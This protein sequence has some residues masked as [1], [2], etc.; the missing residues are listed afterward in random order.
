MKGNRER[1]PTFKYD[2]ISFKTFFRIYRKTKQYL[3]YT[4][5]TMTILHYAFNFHNEIKILM[6]QI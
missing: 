6:I 2:T 1:S 3:Q 4:K 5:N